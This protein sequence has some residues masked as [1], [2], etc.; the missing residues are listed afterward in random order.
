MRRWVIAGVVLG[1]T[2]LFLGIL[3]LGF[4]RDPRAVPFMLKGQP[5]PAFDLAR[6]DDGARV[7]LEDLAGRPVVLNFWASWCGPCKIEHP[8]LEW[9]HREFGGEVQFLGILYED[10]EENARQFLARQP[11]SY[12]QLVDPNSGT[13]VEYGAAGVPETYFITR[14]GKILD[15]H[16]GPIPPQTLATRMRE[17][18]EE[19]AAGS[20]E[21]QP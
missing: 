9:G 17:L 18:L 4:G 11:S 6:L 2:V 1:L 20:A 12:P 19:P 3:A 21:A 15:K 7:R 14:G 16:V 5:A 13:A 8:V 10:T